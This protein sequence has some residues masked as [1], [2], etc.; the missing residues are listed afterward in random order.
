[1]ACT[2]A[3]VSFL[4]CADEDNF[5]SI[6]CRAPPDFENTQASRAKT[7]FTN[8][9][10]HCMIVSIYFVVGSN[11]LNLIN[12]P[13]VLRH[14]C[15][16]QNDFS[17]LTSSAVCPAWQNA[18][19][20][21]LRMTISPRV[22]IWPV[23]AHSITTIGLVMAWKVVVGTSRKFGVVAKWVLTCR[24][25]TNTILSYADVTSCIWTTTSIV[26]S[27]VDRSMWTTK[28]MSRNLVH[29]QRFWKNWMEWRTIPPMP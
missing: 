26:F 1:M 22:P 3:V 20:A 4:V 2:L 23:Y 17:L 11:C 25:A 29:W 16:R 14:V 5:W 19:Q 12:C 8:H 27:R 21:D 18:G 24:M 6:M 13:F 28:E 9:T 7:D 10:G 15:A